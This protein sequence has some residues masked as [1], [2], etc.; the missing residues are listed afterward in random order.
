MNHNDEACS[1]AP[2]LDSPESEWRE[3][4]DAWYPYEASA[5]RRLRT[6]MPADKAQPQSPDE[7]ED[8]AGIVDREMVWYLARLWFATRQNQSRQR[9]AAT[10]MPTPQAQQTRNELFESLDNLDQAGGWK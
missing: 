4:V 9:R 8:L 7:L 2:A 3:W 5:E 6:R 10:L 1:V